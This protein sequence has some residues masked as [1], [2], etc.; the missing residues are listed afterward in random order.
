MKK[1]LPVVVII[2]LISLVATATIILGQLAVSM[3]EED[4][5]GI[6]GSISTVFL[7]FGLAAHLQARKGQVAIFAL[8]LIN[9]AAPVYAYM[10]GPW[11][12]LAGFHGIA[13]GFAGLVL[14]SLHKFETR[15][16]EASE[17][18]GEA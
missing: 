3:P 10:G 8:A 11:N 14:F 17:K 16:G 12:H 13:V 1:A 6:G 18:E 2:N 9:T 7:L 15:S 5:Q 4:L